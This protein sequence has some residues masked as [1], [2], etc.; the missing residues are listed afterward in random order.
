M[1]ICQFEKN[2]KKYTSATVDKIKIGKGTKAQA[3]KEETLLLQ[4]EIK[5]KLRPR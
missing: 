2:N 5:E 1:I 4:K 3:E